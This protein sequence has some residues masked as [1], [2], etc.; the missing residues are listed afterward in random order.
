MSVFFSLRRRHVF[1]VQQV[2]VAFIGV[3]GIYHTCESVRCRN[4]IH[5]GPFASPCSRPFQGT[6]SRAKKTETTREMAMKKVTRTRINSTFE[7]VGRQ[8]HPTKTGDATGLGIENNYE[9]EC[10]KVRRVQYGHPCAS[11]T[12]GGNSRTVSTSACTS[13]PRPFPVP[14]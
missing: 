6:E 4:V 7:T 10:T 12:K 9:C 1:R 14:P 11:A 5:E 8:R 13:V 3:E 2:V